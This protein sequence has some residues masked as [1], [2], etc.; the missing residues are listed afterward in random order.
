MRFLR[1]FW[2]AAGMG[3][4]LSDWLCCVEILLLCWQEA[5]TGFQGERGSLSSQVSPAF[6][7]CFVMDMNM[8]V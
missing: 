5:L 8:Y 2:L 4:E 3:E 6:L 7:C 1:N